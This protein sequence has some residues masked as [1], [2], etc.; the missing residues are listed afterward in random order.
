[1]SESPSSF[2]DLL[3]QTTPYAPATEDEERE[4]LRAGTART[5]PPDEHP[6]TPDDSAP[7]S[8]PTRPSMDAARSFKGGDDRRRTDEVGVWDR[9][10][11]ELRDAMAQ[12]RRF[13]AMARRKGARQ[14]DRHGIVTVTANGFGDIV[15]LTI[16]DRALEYPRQLGDMVTEAVAKAR[17]AGRDIGERLRRLHFP[18]VPSSDDIMTAV[19]EIPSDVRYDQMDYVDSQE[20]KNAIAEHGE[21]LRKLANEVRDFERKFLRCEIGTGAGYIKTNLAENR[22]R[23]RIRPEALRNVGLARLAQ[24]ILTAI[25]N[26]SEQA[27][28]TRTSTFKKA[29][30]ESRIW[31]TPLGDER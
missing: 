19:F 3:G 10:R 1:M 22:V 23:I 9:M 29:L 21:L 4:R 18:A 24:E 16:S 31:P 26:V 6:M 8:V 12:G 13:E 30:V 7:A 15:G 14:T 2:E 28:R 5:R 20:T 17:R 27:I 25:K 11:T